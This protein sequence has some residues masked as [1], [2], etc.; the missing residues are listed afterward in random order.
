MFG[1]GVREKLSGLVNLV[2]G[3]A[4]NEMFEFSV[5]VPFRL[6]GDQC[7]LWRSGPVVLGEQKRIFS[8]LNFTAFFSV[9]I[10]TRSALRLR[11]TKFLGDEE[12]N[13]IKR[14]KM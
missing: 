13:S 4:D 1:S 11:T 10:G 8:V 9:S 12:L 5:L 7:F 2:I 3:G 14:S 6:N